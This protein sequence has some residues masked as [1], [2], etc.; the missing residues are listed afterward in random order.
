[1]LAIEQL[2]FGIIKEYQQKIV[3]AYSERL[4]FRDCFKMLVWEVHGKVSL[5][6]SPGGQNT[7]NQRLRSK[8]EKSDSQRN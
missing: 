4:R 1:M 6:L 8:T 3:V 5:I 7:L 2:N